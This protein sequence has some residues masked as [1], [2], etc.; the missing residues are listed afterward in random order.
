MNKFEKNNI[1][2]NEFKNK[3]KLFIEYKINKK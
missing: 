3:I 2:F 1:F